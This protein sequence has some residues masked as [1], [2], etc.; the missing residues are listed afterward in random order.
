MMF[1]FF[2]FQREAKALT[3]GCA[4][5]FPRCVRCLSSLSICTSWGFLGHY[6]RPKQKGR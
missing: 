3:A 6:L 1:Y 2:S 5:L 4:V